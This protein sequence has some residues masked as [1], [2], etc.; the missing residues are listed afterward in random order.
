MIFLRFKKKRQKNDVYE[1]CAKGKHIR[2]RFPRGKAWRAHYRLQLVHFNICGSMEIKSLGKSS[3]CF[4]FIDDY[5]WMCW[6]VFNRKGELFDAFK[7]FKSLVETKSGY[8]IKCLRINIKGEFCSID[9]LNFCDVNRIRRELTIAY[10]PEKNQV[11]GKKNCTMVKITW[12][13]RIKHLFL[14][15][16]TCYKSVLSQSKSHECTS[17]NESWILV[18]EKS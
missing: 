7:S 6:F 9:F 14:G 4:S 3:Y 15:S 16:C 10:T 1:G 8:K 13:K 18:W 12:Y 2:E 5:S 11:A 17:H